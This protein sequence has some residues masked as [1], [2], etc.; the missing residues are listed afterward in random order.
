MEGRIEELKKGR[1]WIY[2]VYGELG[3]EN[4][5]KLWALSKKRLQSLK[6]WIAINMTEVAFLNSVGMGTLMMIHKNAKKRNGKL[7]LI[8]PIKAVKNS[9]YLTELNKALDIIDNEK[10]I[11]SG[12]G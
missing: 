7:V 11:I 4:S 1:Y 2:K 8:S 6:P 10:D 3:L 12:Q 9:I 5:E